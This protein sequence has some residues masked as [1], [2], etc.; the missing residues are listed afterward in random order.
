MK[1][2]QYQLTN[3]FGVLVD[4]LRDRAAFLEEVRQ[5]IG[6]NHKIIS[7]LIASSTFFAIY[8][9]IIGAS[10]RS[11]TF[12]QAFSSAV[13]LPVLY[14]MTLGICFPTLY[15]FSI[16]FGSRRSFSQ[17]FALLIAAVAVIS[18]LLFAFAPV[19]LF[20]LITAYDYQFFK[21]LNVAILAVTGF[22]GINL[23]YQGMQYMAEQENDEGQATRGKI[24]KLWL[25]LYAIVGC[26]LG[27]TLRPFF[28][29]PGDKTF[30]LF[31]EMEGNFYLNIVEAIAHILGFK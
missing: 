1:K 29:D 22:F 30:V 14:L 25:L 16:L 13:K 26:Q 12:L 4:L 27:W 17:Y 28:G 24:L 23:F 8:G 31:R 11:H 6:L 19:V 3:S 18:V 9:A 7:L 15:F 5:S 20:F 21:L 2:Q 10:D